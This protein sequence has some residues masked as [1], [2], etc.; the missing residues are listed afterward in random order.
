MMF[1]EFGYDVP[2]EDI[3]K[4]YSVNAIAAYL[5]EQGINE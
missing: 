4:L 1:E 2:A 5:N 3:K